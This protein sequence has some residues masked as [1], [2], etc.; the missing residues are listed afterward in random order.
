MSHY[1]ICSI[2]CRP[3]EVRGSQG[4]KLLTNENREVHVVSPGLAAA[5]D[6]QVAN[7]ADHH[8]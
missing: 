6:N 3:E 8:V 7:F 4:Q 5:S 2:G 1:G